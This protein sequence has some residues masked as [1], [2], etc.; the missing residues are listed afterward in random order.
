MQWE[1]PS[2]S[3]Q[4]KSELQL[5]CISL[6]LYVV[7]MNSASVSGLRRKHK[8]IFF[9]KSL[10]C[11]FRVPSSNPPATYSVFGFRRMI[12]KCTFHTY[13][14]TQPRWFEGFLYPPTVQPG[15]CEMGMKIMSWWPSPTPCIYFLPSHALIGACDDC[16]CPNPQ[17]TPVFATKI[18]ITSQFASRSWSVANKNTG[19]F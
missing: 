18:C 8:L 2:S 4:L 1:G 15:I 7:L 3:D 12:N 16:S 6:P 11:W 5:F 9:D 14:A 13:R 10:W 19:I 17:W